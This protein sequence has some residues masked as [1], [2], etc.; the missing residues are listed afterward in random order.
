M[1][2]HDL[3]L[4]DANGA[5]F[6]AD[7]NNA[8]QALGTLQ[9]GSSAPAT[10]YAR[11]LWADTTDNLLKQ[12]NAANSGWIV[13][14]SLD[15]S[16]VL[17]RSSNTILGVADRG[18]T[19]IATAGFTQTLTAAATLGDGWFID[20]IVDSGATLVIDPNSTETVDGSATKSI[21]G[22]AQG[23]LVCNGTLFRTIGFS[24]L[25]ITTRGDLIRGA[26]SG[27]PERVGLGAAGQVLRS[28][29]T[30][31]VWGSPITQSA[32]VASTSGTA[33]EFTGLPSGVKRI[34]VSLNGVSTNGSQNLL[35]Q[36]GDSGGIENSGYASVSA[37]LQ[38]S[39]ATAVSNSTSGLIVTAAM[40]AGEA[41]DGIIILT[42]VDPSTNT[43]AMSANLCDTASTTNL[44]ISAGRKSLSGELDRLQLISATGGDTFDSGSISIQYEV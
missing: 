8:L 25:P 33:I 32:T 10:T 39:T 18:K 1:S 17:S 38:N 21:V 41:L 6:R 15:E 2:Q 7:A 42:L 3:D 24:A 13:R 5:A 36:L 35:I 22:P 40:A 14:G 43:W 20:L 16:F 9:S 37:Y 44:N 11:M 31:A 27:V 19:L 12:R 34:I 30:D 23:R 29:G 26:A 28:D 4:A